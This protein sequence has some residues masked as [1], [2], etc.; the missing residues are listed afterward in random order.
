MTQG[1]L[2]PETP[3]RTAAV[4]APAPV[5][6]GADAALPQDAWLYEGRVMH[7]RLGAVGHRFE[8][9]VWNLAVD[10]DQLDTLSA[11]SRLFGYNRRALVSLWDK[12]YLSGEGSLRQKVDRLLLARGLKA[13]RVVLITVPKV[14]GRVFNPV[15]FYYCYG[16]EGRLLA[17]LAEVNNTFKERHVYFLD[18]PGPSAEGFAA[19][20]T[21]PKD[22]HVSPFNDRSGDY[23]FR[24]SAPAKGLDIGIDILREGAIAMRTRLWGTARSMDD[25]SLAAQLLRM[26]FSAA[27]TYP[28]ILW[29]AA[30]LRFRKGLPVY[31]KPYADSPMTLIPEKSGPWRAWQEGLVFKHFKAL[32]RG[33]LRVTLPDRTVHDF[34]GSE[35]GPSAELTVGNWTF[36]RRLLLSGDIG[37]GESYQE[38]EW[39]SPD[40]CSVI[41]VFGAN[42]D[43]AD[44][45]NLAMALAG[46]AANRLG[47]LLRRNTRSG[48]RRNIA[49][50]YDL[51]N[52]LYAKFLDET[53][54]YSSA[55]F[56]DPGDY[57][58]EPMAEAQRRKARRLLEPLNLKP[59]QHLL[60][61]GCGWGELAA[62]AARDYGVRVTGITLS[63]EQL[64]L[65]RERALDAGVAD[66]VNFEFLD[67]RDLRGR[68][69]AVVSCEMLEAV[70][71]ENLP[72]YFKAVDKALKP[73]GRASLQVITLPDHRYDA[74]RRGT[75][76]IQKHIFPGAVCPSLAA[77]TAAMAKGSRLTVERSEDIGIHYAL[78]LRRWR[79][80]FMAEADSIKGLGFDEK[81]IRTWD[82]YFSYC[83]A[84]FA[85]RLLGNQQLVLRRSGEA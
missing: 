62:I 3:A 65:A 15:N 73:G 10:L 63:R 20:Y 36:F 33:R 19:A 27:L 72:G 21:V 37:L 61:I 68:F 85:G 16:A 71:H 69:D 47:H 29:Q 32:K 82:Y 17:A 8:Y 54:M 48:S 26:P 22:F 6:S 49:A 51:S 39:T 4:T 25:R 52:E 64:K 40:L 5:P 76:W 35:E 74:Y 9:P 60:E 14:L 59:G 57:D 45:R 13:D 41:R 67:Y 23:A 75:D 24:F 11:R 42:L 70:G 80:A 34:G 44:D 79:R 43:L 18:K 66:R 50:H 83:E 56:R 30:L 53:W 2:L 12:D 46:R 31:T 38:G 84:G 78:T 58:Q 77:I 81:F 7:Q 55:V 1:V 28:R